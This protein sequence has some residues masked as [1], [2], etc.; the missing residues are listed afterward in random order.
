MHLFVI[1]T[2]ERYDFQLLVAELLDWCCF[3]MLDAV[4]FER[5]VGPIKLILN[6]G[7]PENLAMVR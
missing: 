2:K 3:P 7:A 5:Q 4:L 1:K 6:F